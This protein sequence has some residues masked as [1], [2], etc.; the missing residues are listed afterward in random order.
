M[1]RIITPW[2]GTPETSAGGRTVTRMD[3][4]RGWD[5][6]DTQARQLR[7]L[8]W[9]YDA[10]GGGAGC[11]V[12]I[13]PLVEQ[14]G[15]APVGAAFTQLRRE[16]LV[17]EPVTVDE[18]AA[19]VQSA[20]TSAGV[21][22]VEQARRRRGDPAARRPAARDALLRWLYDCNDQG[23][24]SPVLNGF[25]E[26]RYASFYGDPFTLQEI[27]AASEWL[28]EQGYLSGTGSWGH[29][30]PC[31]TITAAGEQLVEQ[32]RSVNDPTSAGSIHHVTYTITD[33]QAI[34]IAH[35][36]PHT[37]QTATITITDEQQQQILAVADYLEQA[38]PQLG[39]PTQEAARIPRLVD[40]LRTA[41]QEPAAD[42]GRLRQLIDTAR[43]L[44][45]AA[46][47]VPLGAGLLA[48]IDQTAKALGL[49]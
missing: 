22:V 1:K 46:G 10:A 27:E 19:P 11:Y 47:G 42:R 48:L 3:L 4:G 29:G 36:S 35:G 44:G 16:D 30:I 21:E 12:D 23:N 14:D 40:E 15:D 28:T 25:T 31:P 7:V 43:Q 38:A 49:S 34:N 24:P 8:E 37:Q 13:Q 6:T 45:I 20:L 33:S 17:D 2:R 41:A 9:L 5:L 18:L 32:G 26:S 39:L